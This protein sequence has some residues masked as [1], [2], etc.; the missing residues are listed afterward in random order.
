MFGDD[1]HERGWHAHD[2]PMPGYALLRSHPKAKPHHIRTRAMSPQDVIALPDRPI[3]RREIASAAPPGERPA[4]RLVKDEAPASTKSAAETPAIEG[5]T[6]NQ[7]AV[8][9]AVEGGASTNAA[10]AKATGLNPGSVDRAV[11]ALVKRGLIVKDGT[12]I[13]MGGAA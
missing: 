7:L 3:W 5:L 9:R 1:A 6:D 4:L 11:K 12:E 10:I 13:R 2:L 8:L